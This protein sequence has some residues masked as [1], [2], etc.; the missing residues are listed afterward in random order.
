MMEQEMQYVGLRMSFLI[1]TRSHTSGY[2]Y[3]GVSSQ[4]SIPAQ[5]AHE[6][7]MWAAIE[8]SQ[9]AMAQGSQPHDHR[10]RPTFGMAGHPGGN[11]APAGLAAGSLG[12]PSPGVPNPTHAPGPLSSPRGV[13]GFPVYVPSGSP[14]QPTVVD[15]PSEGGFELPTGLLDED[16]G[17]DLW[18]AIRA[19]QEEFQ[20]QLDL[21]T[22]LTNGFPSGGGSIW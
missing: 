4:G 16:E 18:G 12:S 15:A 21:G 22:G 6:L 20:N 19:E 13:D 7:A 2:R 3:R 8:G 5:D 14:P 1:S 9:R 17:G 10:G 11:L